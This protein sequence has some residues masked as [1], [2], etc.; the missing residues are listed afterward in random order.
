MSRLAINI[1]IILFIGGFIV[2]NVFVTPKDILFGVR[3]PSE[4]QLIPEVK[5]IRKRFI[6]G[7]VGITIIMLILAYVQ[8]RLYPRWSLMFSI[9][10][11][12]IILLVFL[13]IYFLSWKRAKELKENNIWKTSGKAYYHS[14]V[15]WQ[16]K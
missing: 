3:I 7:M 13:F 15:W 5:K 4:K 14:P 8:F 16:A 1:F 9:N 6:I 10:S 2:L 11:P 12:L